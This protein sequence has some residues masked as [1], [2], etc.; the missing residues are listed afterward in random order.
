[1]LSSGWNRKNRCRFVMIRRSAILLLLLPVLARAETNSSLEFT[2][3]ALAL[4]SKFR[5]F[6]WKDISINS[7]TWEYYRK[8]SRDNPLFFKVFGSN[9]N[10]STIFLGGVHGDEPAP[11]YILT[12]LALY[13]QDHPEYY[14]D[15]QIVIAPLINP[16]GF[17]ALKSTRT[18]GRGVDLNRNLP[19]RNWTRDAQ[20]Q[21]KRNEH[22]SRRKFPGELPGSESETKFQIA[23]LNRF[24]PQ[25]IISIHSPLGFYDYDGATSELDRLGQWLNEVSRETNFP[26]NKYKVYPGSLG[27]YAG[28][29]R[30]IFTIT[31]E[32]PSSEPSKAN[33]YF[34]LF[35]QSFIKLTE[36]RCCNGKGH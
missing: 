12:R 10:N 2:R 32:L 23:L 8:T 4:E 27:N 28:V 35:R 7:V 15:K 25:K 22:G 31:L 33:D 6:G 36:L 9:E 24:S 13:L 21:W 1:M 20:S 34:D 14:K 16:D 29:E 19:T 3:F 5:H 30:R 26:V 18:N 17:V 11:V